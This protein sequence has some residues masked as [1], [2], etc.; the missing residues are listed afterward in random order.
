[1]SNYREKNWILNTEHPLG[2]IRPGY[3]GNQQGAL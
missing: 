2:T 1:M 3:N